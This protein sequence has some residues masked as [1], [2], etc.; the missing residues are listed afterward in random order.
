MYYSIRAFAI[1]FCF[2]SLNFCTIRIL[3][4]NIQYRIFSMKVHRS[5]H[6]SV[7][8]QITT[9]FFTEF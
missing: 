9:C 5:T 6:R 4:E 7:I 8:L 3:Q 2:D 1:F